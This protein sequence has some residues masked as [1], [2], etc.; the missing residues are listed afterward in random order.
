MGGHVLRWSRR[1]VVSIGSSVLL[2][3]VLTEPFFIDAAMP[4][5]DWSYDG[6]LERLRQ[7]FTVIADHLRLN[8]S[9]QSFSFTHYMRLLISPIVVVVI[10]SW[11]VKYLFM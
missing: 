11:I 6:D 10:L 8:Y 4:G 1:C 7:G 2:F 3:L 9:N 5:A